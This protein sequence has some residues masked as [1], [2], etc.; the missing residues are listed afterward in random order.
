MC[1]SDLTGDVR[2]NSSFAKVRIHNTNNTVDLIKTLMT[3]FALSNLSGGHRLISMGG[4]ASSDL[5]S[6]HIFCWDADNGNLVSQ[7]HYQPMT[8]YTP[9][10]PAIVPNQSC[11]F[12]GALSGI[13][14]SVHVINGGGQF[15]GSYTWT[16]RMAPRPKLYSCAAG[17]IG[18]R[19]PPSILI[20]P[21]MNLPSPPY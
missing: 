4:P 7:H 19:I 20:P 1:K 16:S 3:Y 13:N 12:Y 9:L 8:K 6:I 18:R 15:V 14:Y 21:K 5:P 17:A 11:V 10:S 2:S